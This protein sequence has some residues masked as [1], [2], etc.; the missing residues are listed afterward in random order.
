MIESLASAG[1]FL[2]G[3]AS[4]PMQA[5][6]ISLLDPARVRREAKALRTH[7]QKKRDLTVS[8]LG[9]MGLRVDHIPRG[10]FYCWTSL[11]D[12]A[13]PLRDDM[14][15]FEVGFAEKVITVPGSFFDV[16]PG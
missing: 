7:F 15:F 10:A 4:H 9:A 14:A 16:N 8:R 11:A 12:L 3:G 6:A 5:A 13:S 2:D 1:S